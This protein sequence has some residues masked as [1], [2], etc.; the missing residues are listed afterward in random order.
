M[1][2]LDLFP[3]A[4]PVNPGFHPVMIGSHRDENGKEYSEGE[5]AAVI[6]IQ[7][8]EG[9]GADKAD[10]ENSQSPSCERC[11]GPRS[12]NNETVGASDN[13]LDLSDARVGHNGRPY[14]ERMGTSNENLEH[15][16][17]C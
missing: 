10:E 4:K 2:Q 12:L 3:S 16:L 9:H 11:T 17:I 13:R 8:I 5:V 6:P 1:S 7:L 14:W 15:L